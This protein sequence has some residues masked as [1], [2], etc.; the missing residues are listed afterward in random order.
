MSA[1][2]N[3]GRSNLASVRVIITRVTDLPP[4]FQNVP[5]RTSVDVN[6]AIN[7]TVFQVLAVDPDGLVSAARVSECLRE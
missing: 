3:R 4:V 2:D 5:Y 1:R 6:R 7:S